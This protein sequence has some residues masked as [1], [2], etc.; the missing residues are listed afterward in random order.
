M[1]KKKLFL[2]LGCT[3][4]ILGL[5][6]IIN[7]KTSITGAVI[8]GAIQPSLSYIFGVFLLLISGVFISKPKRLDD[9]I[10][11]EFVKVGNLEYNKHAL[12]R[13]EERNI[14][15][16]VIEEV[17]KYGEHYKL[18]HA[19]PSKRTTGTTDAYIKRHCASILEGGGRIGERIIKVRG[20]TEKEDYQNLVVLTDKDRRVK[21]VI[22]CEDDRL[23]CYIESTFA[24]NGAFSARYSKIYISSSY[25]IP[26]T[27]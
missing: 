2:V 21:T 19:K 7:G 20:P 14:F 23:S 4:F 9:K 25:N 27:N 22:I 6:F 15:P 18:K 10:E 8:G 1:N 24:K 16:I 5:F 11:E 12:E 26:Y 13:I 17:I 3:S